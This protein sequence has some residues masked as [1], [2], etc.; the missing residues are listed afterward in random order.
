MTKEYF[1]VL[2]CICKNTD[3]RYYCLTILL[4]IAR[5]F[6]VFADNKLFPKTSEVMLAD[7]IG[8]ICIGLLSK[9]EMRIE[10]FVTYCLD[11]TSVNTYQTNNIAVI[12]FTSAI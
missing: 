1:N 10:C 12:A 8:Y 3:K 11:N 9:V 2:F 7:E 5:Y 4:W 6:Q